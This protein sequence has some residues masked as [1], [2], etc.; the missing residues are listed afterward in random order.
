MTP[1]GNANFP[2]DRVCTGQNGVYT[3]ALT[4]NQ[5]PY[6]QYGTIYVFKDYQDTL[7]VTV[8][9]DGPD[10]P[11]NYPGQPLVSIPAL[12]Q[13]QLFATQLF[14]WPML[15][16]S[17]LWTS[18][19]YNDQAGQGRFSCLTFTVNTN[20]ACNPYTSKHTTDPTI[21]GGKNGNCVCN[22]YANV[23]SATTGESQ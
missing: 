5:A 23:Q 16:F 14:A 2:Y 3:Q 17:K 6:T 15:D 21:T 4:S 10:Y 9:I 13:P 19:N 18:S 11:T 20:S 22:N 8:A 1:N 7:Y 12:N